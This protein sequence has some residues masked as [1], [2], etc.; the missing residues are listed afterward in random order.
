[1]IASRIMK[2]YYLTCGKSLEEIK[3]QAHLAYFHALYVIGGRWPPGELAIANYDWYALHY[4]KN[5]LEGPFTLGEETLKNSE[6]WTEY[7]SIFHKNNWQN[8]F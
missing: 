8:G 6:Y 2:N 7:V 1:M 5:I 3:N 4:A